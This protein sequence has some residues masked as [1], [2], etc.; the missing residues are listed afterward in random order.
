MLFIAIG[1]PI[2]LVPLLG[3]YDAALVT[4]GTSPVTSEASSVTSESMCSPFH[5]SEQMLYKTVRIEYRLELVENAMT[6]MGEQMESFAEDNLKQ[7]ETMR[8]AMQSEQ[9]PLEEFKEEIQIEIR[10]EMEALN[11]LKGISTHAQHNLLCFVYSAARGVGILRSCSVY[12]FM[13][14]SVCKRCVV[15]FESIL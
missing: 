6:K 15:C 8:N 3:L 10:N 11:V 5:Y 9:L 2:F 7:L 14:Q 4:S 12:R 1:F 13:C